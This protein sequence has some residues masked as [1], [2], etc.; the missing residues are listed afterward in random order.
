MASR[1]LDISSLLCDDEQVPEPVI[2]APHLRQPSQSSSS[3]SSSFPRHAPSPSTSPS[4]QP[5][6]P[7]LHSHRPSSSRHRLSPPSG[8]NQFPSPT[9][10]SNIQS[11]GLEAL[12]QAATEERRRLTVSSPLDHDVH[13]RPSPPIPIQQPPHFPHQQPLYRQHKSLEDHARS[14]VQHHSPILSPA[15]ILR[16]PPQPILSPVQLIRSPV[17]PQHHPHPRNRHRDEPQA[18]LSTPED[19]QYRSPQSAYFSPPLQPPRQQ[20]ILDH[21]TQ[22][23]HEF[24]RQRMHHEQLLL[25]EQH[26]QQQQQYVRDRQPSYTERRVLPQSRAGPSVPLHV[27]APSHH[28]S[29]SQHPLPHPP[30]H[31]P[32]LLIQPHTSGRKSD[33]GQ[34]H[35]LLHPDPA[36]PSLSAPP[37]SQPMSSPETALHPNKK[38]RY[39]DLPAQ[40]MFADEKDPPHPEREKVAAGEVAYGRSEPVGHAGSRRPGSGYGHGRK[41]LG[42]VELMSPD[43]EPPRVQPVTVEGSRH[44]GLS[45]AGLLEE[46]TREHASR[47]V[48][49][50][51]VN[52]RE[53]VSHDGH[54]REGHRSGGL[55]DGTPREGS[56]REGGPREGGSRERHGLVS[57]HRRRSPPGS[58]SGRAI[59]AKKTEEVEQSLHDLLAQATEPPRIP[60]KETDSPLQEK[61]GKFALHERESK[62]V[63]VEKSVMPAV[64]EIRTTLPDREVKTVISERKRPPSKATIDNTPD[65]EPTPAKK[66]RTAPAAAASASKA[67]EED[68]HEWFL[69]HFDDYNVP[70]QSRPPSP[71]APSPPASPALPGRQVK[72]GTPPPTSMPDAAD[73]LEQELEEL[74]G[75]PLPASKA[76]PDMDMDVDLVTELVA[77]TLDANDTKAQDVGMEVDVEDELLSLLD[78]RPTV[79]RPVAKA[80]SPGPSNV[81]PLLPS[82]A[83][84]ARNVSPAVMSVVSVPSPATLLPPAVR[85]SSTHPTPN[86]GSMPPPTSVTPGRVKDKEEK[87]TERGGSAAAPATK[88]KDALS[89]STA[90]NKA[91]AAVSAGTTSAKSRAKPGPKP[92]LKTSDASVSAKSKAATGPKKSVVSRSRSTSVMPSGS[93]GP[94]G[95]E[96][97]AAEKQEEEEESDR[98]DDKLYCVCKTTYDEDRFMIACDRTTYKARCLYGLRHPDPSSPKACHRPAHGAFSKYCSKECGLKYMQSRADAWAKKGG[99]KDELWETVKDAEKREGVV[100]CAGEPNGIKMM[101]DKEEEEHGLKAKKSKVEREVERLNGVLD[102][103]VRLRED[104]KK[105]MES[106]I[107]R[108]KLLE[109]ATAR[110]ETLGECGWD[111]RLCFGDDECANLGVGALESY[112]T[113]VQDA[114]TGPSSGNWW[115]SGKKVCD[116][117]AGWQTVRVK[118][119]CKEKE[120]KNAALLNLTTREREIRKRIEDILDPHGYNCNDPSGKSPLK[121][122]NTKLSNGHTKEKTNGDTTTKK[123]K[124]RKAP[125]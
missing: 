25:Q 112:D 94:E 86:R 78:D 125:S 103:V 123:G 21:R 101:I 13:R 105:E 34:Y 65:T 38:R 70:A 55:H 24:E 5:P 19:L 17:Y 82:D 41:H 119:V 102:S 53:G 27:E 117:H 36:H 15:Q 85:P 66:Q 81:K 121:A 116:R 12:V 11:F 45:E 37:F 98:E 89:K 115:C 39:S 29:Q 47:E 118:D 31:R 49:P 75:V 16:S 20:V 61:D 57:P 7:M 14:P 4:F 23:Q 69:E 10:P 122:S 111:Q 124:K 114:E 8:P 106:V 93:A 109:L 42:L 64:K 71:R 59:A 100:V 91:T 51:V 1:R 107:W 32:S 3:P 40:T 95:S 83:A 76:E 52:S 97:K 2:L 104:V 67:A 28:Q 30:L 44:E 92:K 84:S 9:I 48:V 99:K 113:K 43:H 90:K 96:A 73:E 46:G 18:R 35:Q 77:E 88:K 120:K 74:L 56:S 108:E 87:S 79:R 58:H 50:R 60:E 72:A 26:L 6:P 63:P 68:A 33:P 110:A 80:A 62:P 22:Q 54:S